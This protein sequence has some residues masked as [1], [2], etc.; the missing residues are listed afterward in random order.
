MPKPESEE[1][2]A[3]ERRLANEMQPALGGLS[4]ESNLG[5]AWKVKGMGLCMFKC[6]EVE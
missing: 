4:R 6:R 2:E 5:E 3:P 1:M